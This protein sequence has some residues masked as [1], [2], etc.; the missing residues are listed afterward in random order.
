M[1]IATKKKLKAD[2]H[3]LK[4]VIIVGAQ[5]VS[6]ALIKETSYALLAHE[7]I[8]IKIHAEDKTVRTEAAMKLCDALKAELIQLIGHV[9]IIYKKNHHKK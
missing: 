6:D 8:K 2:A 3:H 1:N 9:A 5:G 7:L 4:P